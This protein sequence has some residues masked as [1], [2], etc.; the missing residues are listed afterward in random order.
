MW[1]SLRKYGCGTVLQVLDVV[2]AY[3]FWMWYSHTKYGC[4]TVIQVLDIVEQAMMIIYLHPMIITILLHMNNLISYLFPS[5][6]TS[7]VSCWEEGEYYTGK[8]FV[9]LPFWMK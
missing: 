4:G 9:A 6:P 3:K 8:R 5:R 2:Q 1:Y 7:V